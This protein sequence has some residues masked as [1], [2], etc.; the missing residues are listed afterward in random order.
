MSKLYIADTKRI[1][2]D[3]L[4][5]ITCIIAAV[6]SF[7]NP[8]LYKGFDMIPQL[9]EI[10]GEEAAASELKASFAMLLGAINAKVLLFAS[11]L[12]GDNL[13]LIMPILISIIVCKDFSQGTVRNKIISGKARTKIFF[14]HLLSSSTVICGI[15]LFHAM[16]TLVIALLF[17]PYQDTAFGLSD[18]GYLLISL[19]FEIIV[20]FAISSIVTLYATVS[21]NM[22][23]C[24]LLYLASALGLSIVGSITQIAGAAAAMST[25]SPVVGEMIEFIN[26]MNFYTAGLIGGGTTYDLKDVLYIILP[27]IITALFSTV[28][29]I[30]LFSRKN[31]K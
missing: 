19:L 8:L 24:I 10:F 21:K 25:T 2:N 5:W 28:S 7:I 29:G 12:P 23:I 22:G 31:L 18:L 16:L 4:F 20:Y 13:G 6:F 30:F 3:K 9:L 27:P 14:S 26:A 17:F 11:L 15:M 1:L